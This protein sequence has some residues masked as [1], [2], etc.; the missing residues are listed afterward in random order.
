MAPKV[1]AVR[2]DFVDDTTLPTVKVGSKT[3]K[4]R[5]LRLLAP[6]DYLIRAAVESKTLKCCA[7]ATSPIRWF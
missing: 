4:S 2:D 1:R 6:A 5:I 3:D 7:A